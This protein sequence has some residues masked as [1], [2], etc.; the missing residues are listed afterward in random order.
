MGEVYVLVVRGNYGDDDV[1]GVFTDVQR[2][3]QRG[4][5]LSGLHMT[6]E[7]LVLIPD[8]VNMPR[9]ESYDSTRQ[10]WVVYK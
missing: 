4:V 1:I 10:K 5:E 6:V 3:R 7:I 2:A 8:T 9:I